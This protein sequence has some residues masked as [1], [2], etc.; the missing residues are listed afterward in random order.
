MTYSFSLSLS[1]KPN[2]ICTLLSLSSPAL[3][4]LK[5][6]IE[7]KNSSGERAD[8]V[9][10]ASNQDTKSIHWIR[11]RSTESCRATATSRAAII[12][13]K[14]S[15]DNGPSVIEKIGED[16]YTNAVEPDDI[17]LTSNPTDQCESPDNLCL[18]EIQSLNKMPV[19]LT[20]PKVDVKMYLP[21]NFSTRKTTF[22]GKFCTV[23]S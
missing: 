13:Y 2:R 10:K 3:L 7:I 9:L 14:H 17:V 1:I 22:L 23:K 20:S 6:I 8:F 18:T 11:L 21:I 4:S 16:K 15:M 12:Q 19:E 5:L